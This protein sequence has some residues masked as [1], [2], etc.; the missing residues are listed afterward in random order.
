MAQVK[1]YYDQGSFVPITTTPGFYANPIEV[2]EVT[3]RQCEMLRDLFDHLKVRHAT[4]GFPRDAQTLAEE[5][6]VLLSEVMKT[7]KRRAKDVSTD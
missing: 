4:A 5:F 1:A 7:T 6:S 2:D 3:V